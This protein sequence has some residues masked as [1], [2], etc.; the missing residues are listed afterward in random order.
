M[1][2]VTLVVFSLVISAVACVYCMFGAVKGGIR[3][4]TFL[5]ELQN[6]EIE[7]QFITI[8]PYRDKLDESYYGL[9]NAL[10][11]QMTT[12]YFFG[13]LNLWMLMHNLARVL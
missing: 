3:Y 2:S 5:D 1:G 6:W 12:G 9:R 7:K 8:K 4:W 13:C 11:I 10:W